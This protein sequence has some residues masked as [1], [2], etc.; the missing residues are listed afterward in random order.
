M[1]IRATWFFSTS[2]IAVATAAAPVQAQTAA[3]ATPPQAPTTI[4]SAATDATG[5]VAQSDP[6]ADGPQTSSSGLED[7]VVTATRRSSNL[8]RVTATVEAVTANTLKAYNITGVLQL[9]S[10]VSGLVVTPA[11]GNNLYL[12][13][14]GS[15]STGFNEAQTATYID[16]LYLA[17]PT[18]GITSFNN[19]E[20][21][22]VLKGPQGTLYGRNVTG[23][24]IS[25]TTRDPGD[26]VRIDGSVGYANYNTL[27]GN[28]YA[29]APLTDNLG[30]NIAVFHQKQADG[31]SVNVFN[32]H[33]VQKSDETGLEAKIQWRPTSDLKITGSFIY[34]Y[35]NRD[36][37]Y[38]YQVYPGSLGTDGTPYLGRYRIAS[39]IDASAPTSI[40]IGTLKIEQSLGF[41]TLTSLTGY[42]TSQANVL[43]QNGLPILGQVAAGQGASYNQFYERNRTFSQ[44]LTL[45]SAPSSSRFDWVAGAFFYDD[46]LKLQLDTYNTCLGAVCAPGAAPNRINGLPSTLS[47]SVYGDGT[48]RFFKATRLTVGLRYTDET[49]RLGGLTTPL[50]GLPNSVAALPATTILY[51]GQP[52]AGYPNGIPT[53]LHFNKL[54][55][56]FV[57]AQ[58]LNDNVHMYASHNLGFKSGAFNANSFTNPPVRPELLYA[59][60]AGVKSELFDRKLRLNLS[61]F[62]YTYKDVQ[63]RSLVPPATTSAILENAASEHLD[64]V[65]ADFSA[66]LFKGFVINGSFEYLAAHYAAFPGAS[67]AT[68]RKSATGTL[69][70]GATVINN[71]DLA[72]FDVPFAAP[73]SASLRAT[74]TFDTTRGDFSLSVNDHYNSPYSMTVDSSIRQG[75]HNI[76]DLSLNWTAPSKRYDVN[77]FV[78]NLTNQYT[79][80]AAVVSSNFAVVPGPPRIFGGSFGFHF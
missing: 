46:H 34:D 55:Y 36:L 31:W 28:L 49:K 48:Y 67:L 61:Y 23:G 4:P 66:A 71:Y 78:R 74:Y 62:H 11:G 77:L 40:Y 9:P 38:A 7:I 10:L 29:S 2:L 75:R 30:V 56:R 45:T 16:G 41:A 18:V 12:R 76:V 80:A 19:V 47:G 21:I 60:E 51:P 72:G 43:F 8:Q 15:A 26:K 65:D 27:T 3:P 33:D 79:Y 14:I 69:L 44:E 53:R 39:R 70:P 50:P 35:N 1:M 52:F 37:G 5:A 54:T 6:T 63:V 20:R 73:V 13:G 68:T 32:G 42:Q 22:E 25:V 64:G 57:L 17:N 59:T 58:D 24:L